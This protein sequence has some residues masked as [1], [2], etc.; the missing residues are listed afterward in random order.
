PITLSIQLQN[1]TSTMIQFSWKPQGGTGD[2]PYTVR[3]LGKS[4][5][6]EKRIL[7]E[8]SISFENLLSGHQYQISVDVSTCSKNVSTS[9]TVQTAAEVY[10]GTTRIMNKV[11]KSEYQNK[12]STEF[13]EFEKKFIMEV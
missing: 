5:G 10:R 4:G 1:V 12:S 3:L 8:T 2:S 9:L 6:M 13:K 11:F 7:N